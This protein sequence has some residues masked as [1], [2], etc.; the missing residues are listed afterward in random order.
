MGVL[1]TTQR[2]APRGIR[3]AS[4]GCARIGGGRT[5]CFVLALKEE[6]FDESENSNGE[7]NPRT[8][9]IEGCMLSC[10]G[11]RFQRC[12]PLKGYHDWGIGVDGVIRFDV[13]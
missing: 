5:A 9:F 11:F 3:G 10:L 6:R 1:G 8:E 7:G 12:L 13:V 4:V 2:K